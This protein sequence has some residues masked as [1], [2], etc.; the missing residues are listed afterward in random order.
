MMDPDY[1]ER[2]KR[3]NSSIFV[4]GFSF[5]EADY[6]LAET[7]KTFTTLGVIFEQRVILA[8]YMLVGEAGHW[9]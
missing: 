4:E 5:E 7:E 1:I 3:L 2:Y 6:W 8:T 9:W